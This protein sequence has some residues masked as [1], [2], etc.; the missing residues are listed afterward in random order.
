M[1]TH[2]YNF[3]HEFFFFHQKTPP[4]PQEL[5]DAVSFKALFTNE[6]LAYEKIIP[7][8]EDFAKINLKTA[9]FYYADLQSN[10]ATL[11]TGDF[12]CHDW[13]LPKDKV[14]LSLEHT[15]LAVKYL[16]QFHAAGFALRATDKVKFEHLT[17]GLLESRYN[18]EI[19]HPQFLLKIKCGMDRTVKVCREQLQHLLPEEY[20]K[21][22]EDLLSDCMAYG[23]K[24]VHPREPYVTLCHGDFLRNNVAYKYGGDSEP[25]DFMMFDLQTL[26]VSSP[27]IDLTTFLGLSTFA[28]MR[29]KHFKDILQAYCEQ[30][31]ESYEKFSNLPV[32]EYLRFVCTLECI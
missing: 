23:R 15:L 5:F 13:K 17:E 7:A 1:F 19:E 28:E 4:L 21:K 32:P 3:E 27:M 26:R 24:L 14:N 29:Q 31:K 12:T 9:K 16:A 22:Y 6:I 25:I 11:I 10:A 2:Q 30:L 20:L 8:L 18:A